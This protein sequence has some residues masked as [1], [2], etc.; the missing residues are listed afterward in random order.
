MFQLYSEMRIRTKLKISVHR[1]AATA[2]RMK[3]ERLV[4]CS[5]MASTM[6]LG[7]LT[8][9][10]TNGSSVIGPS[11]WW[12]R[13][14]RPTHDRGSLLFLSLRGTVD[15]PTIRGAS[16]H[17]VN[18]FDFSIVPKQHYDLEKSAFGVQPD[19]EFSLRVVII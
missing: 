1:Q 2:L 3:S 15:K 7:N 17:R 14:R 10:V 18:D 19:S 9:T 11:P 16:F 4:D 12:M 6:D 8:G 5:F 13:S